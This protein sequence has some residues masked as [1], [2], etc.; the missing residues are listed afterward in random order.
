MGKE[1]KFEKWI[2]RLTAEERLEIARQR[3]E[4][5]VLHLK[6]AIYQ[7]ENNRIFVLDEE[8][9]RRVPTS[10]A[11]HAFHLTRLMLQKALVLQVCK[12]WDSAA[13]D[14]DSLPTV[15]ALLKDPAVL[16][17]CREEN[18]R[19]VRTTQ[20][21]ELNLADANDVAD[22]RNSELSDIIAG[23]DSY[24][25]EDGNLLGLIRYRDKYIAHSLSGVADAADRPKYGNIE[26][27][28]GETKNFL[29]SLLDCVCR[30]SHSWDGYHEEGQ[31]HARRLWGNCD[32][33]ID[34][35][36]LA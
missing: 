32:F 6:S 5:M 27:L 19:A 11:R 7:Y 9:D 30:T 10:Y 34:E 21:N 20:M 26:T 8:F 18:F 36:D 35:S 23:I 16:D 3:I 17:A 4:Q 15:A 13:S 1:G 2:R 12:L 28:L 14:R 24:R 31:L 29:D 25:S 22:R 33:R